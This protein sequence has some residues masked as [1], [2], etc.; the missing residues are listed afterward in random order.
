M[1]AIKNGLAGGSIGAVGDA[2]GKPIAKSEGIPWDVL[3]YV[4][5]AFMLVLGWSVGAIYL[6]LW[7]FGD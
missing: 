6:I 3:V 7:Y 2:A 1:T 4:L 5:G